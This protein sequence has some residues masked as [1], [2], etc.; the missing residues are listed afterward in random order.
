MIDI[1]HPFLQA[2][3]VAA[4]AYALGSIPFGLLV[5][6]VMGLGDL[7]RLGSGN[8]GAT[9]VLRTGSKTA[10]LATVLLD[11]GKGV[12]AVL[13]AAG[14][15]GA[16]VCIAIAAVMSVLGHCFPAWLR[17][18]GGKGVATG[19]GVVLAMQPLAGIAMGL[20]WLVA[21]GVARISSLASLV[22]YGCCPI[23]LYLLSEAE[24]KGAFALA[25]LAIAA[26]SWWRHRGN[27]ARILEGNEPRIGS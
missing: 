24:A 4:G 19:I 20:A 25:G 21:A 23:A 11:G 17:F 7:R 8:I 5:A 12:A 14:L 6:R 26:V 2:S 16:P 13:A 3:L 15:T 27:I 1:S 9:N 22:A 18:R 10:A